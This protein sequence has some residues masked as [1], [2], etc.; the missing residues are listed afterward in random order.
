MFNEG[1]RA[2]KA[3]DT[4][5]PVALCNGDLLFLDIIVDECPDIDILGTNMYRGVSFGDAFERVKNEYGKPL[6]FTE[7]GADAFSAI[8]NDEDQ[9]SQAF[10]MT[11]NWKEIYANAAGMGKA[12]NSIGGFTFQFSDGWWKFGQTKNLSVHDNN[13]SWSNGGYQK[14]FKQGEN[15]MNEEW[16]GICAKGPTGVNGMYELFPRASY[17]ALKSAHSFNPYEVGSDL[18]T[19]ENHFKNEVLL[20]DAVLQARGD[21]AALQSEKSKYIS[22]SRFTAEFETFNTGG[23]L[24][25][26]PIDEDPNVRQ[27]PDELGFDHM[28]SFYVGVQA[29]PAPNVRAEVVFNMVGN[30]AENPIDEIFYENRARP[31]TVNTT[32]GAVEFQDVNR[33]QVY[34]AS[35]NWNHKFFNLD[36]FYRTGHFHWGYEGDFFG[37]YP[38]ANYG[39]NI[40]IYNG[41]APLGFEI[42]G[43]KALTGL[44]LAFGPELWWGAN[45]ALLVKYQKQF[46]NYEVAGIFHEDIAQRGGT[47]SSFAIP[48]PKTRRATLYVHGDY[49]KFGVGLGGIWG[50]N[51]L[52]GRVYQVTR[53][54]DNN[55]EVFATTIKPQDNWGGKMKVTYTGGKFNWYAQGAA[56]GLVANGGADATLTYTG[57]RLKDSGSGNQYNFLT[58]LTYNIGDL[59]IAPNFLWQ[60]PVEGP[61][62]ADVQAPGR[63]RNIL[64]DPFVVRGN[65]EQIGAEILFTYD[66]TPATYYYEWDNDFAEDAKF[67]ANLGVIFRHLPTSQDAAIGILPNGRTAFAFP[68]AAPAQDLWEA[69]AR[70]VSKIN[71]E[72]GIIGN[73]YAGKAQANGDS[74][75]SINRFGSDIRLIYKQLKVKYGMKIN[76]WGPYDYHRDF[77]LTFPVQMV[78]DISTILEKPTWLYVPQTKIGIMGTWRSLNQYSNRYCP[79]TTTDLNGNTVCVSDLDGYD[80]GNEWEIRAYI[81]LNIGAVR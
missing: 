37:L 26:T 73:F 9:E 58:G 59:Q 28:Q 36:A 20:A 2:I 1:A 39:E 8:N 75:R 79:A 77:N 18:G 34:S 29:N 53:G 46:K 63:L 21:K 25:S 68:A 47:Q 74:E 16:F 49:G 24:I 62:L 42:E 27:Y 6:L 33:F 41:I 11:G 40:D 78:L 69:H 55:P 48:Q 5:H 52:N 44:K 14:D 80:N 57:W 70:I 3:L 19:L 23:S 60:K 67:A 38:E 65:R 51:P 71:P 45:P 81:H 66:P 4:N 31:L 61:M 43:K 13:A 35:F 72:L 64:D 12:G 15:N 56:M 54:D 22:L 10:Y 7:F 32:T 30:V 76:D 17:Y 50:G